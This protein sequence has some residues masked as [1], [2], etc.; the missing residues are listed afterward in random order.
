VSN[1]DTLTAERIRRVINGYPFQGLRR[2]E[3]LRQRLTFT[4]LQK[5]DLLLDRVA[6]TESRESP[7]F[8]RIEKTVKDGEL[9]VSGIH[10]AR[11]EAD[12]LGGYFTF[13]SLGE[14][15]EMDRLLTGETL[16]AAETLGTLLF[17][18][19]T[20][21]VQPNDGSGSSA[22]VAGCRY[23]GES[24][25]FH[26]WLLYRPDLDFLKSRDAA[27][28]LARAEALASARPQGKRHLLFAAAKFVSQKLL[29]EK[30]LSVEFAPLPFALYRVERG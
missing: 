26:V 19:A 20:N 8:D 1:Y 7:R 6:E 13:C 16:P 10:E 12:G 14:P 23:L 11:E 24:A 4:R 27:L 25:T 17:H 28:T 29:D 15:I 3:L 18:M 5:A 21:E 22:D 9:I 2:E 30:R